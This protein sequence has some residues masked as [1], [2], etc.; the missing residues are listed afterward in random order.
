MTLTF[1]LAGFMVS[2]AD[3]QV[4]GVESIFGVPLGQ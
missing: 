4:F 1:I 3:G 2:A